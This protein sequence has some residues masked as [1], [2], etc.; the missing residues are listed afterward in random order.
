MNIR[1]KWNNHLKENNMTYIEHLIFALYYGL[2]CLLAGFYLIVHSIFP[3]FF[4]TT[5]SDLVNKLSKRFGKNE[6]KK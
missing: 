6:N 4:P 1:K 5:G 3:C 2:C